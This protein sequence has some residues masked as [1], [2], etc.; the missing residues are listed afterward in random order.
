MFKLN[1]LVDIDLGFELL[2]LIEKFIQPDV[3]IHLTTKNNSSDFI[4]GLIS[5]EAIENLFYAKRDVKIHLLT[6]LH[7]KFIIVDDKKIFLGSSNFTLAT[8]VRRETT[9]T[10]S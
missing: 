7:A 4:K 2:D 3:E 5:I 6:N 10:K 8:W 9:V 1:S